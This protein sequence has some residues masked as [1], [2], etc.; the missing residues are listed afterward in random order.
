[1]RR[2]FHR[3]AT[4]AAAFVTV[5]TVSSHASAATNPLRCGGLS[6]G[7]EMDKVG[8]EGTDPSEPTT[9]QFTVVATGCSTTGAVLTYNTKNGSATSPDDFVTQS[10]TLTWAAGDSSNPTITVIITRDAVEEAPE[11]DFFVQL[12]SRQGSDTVIVDGEAVGR[13][14]D[15]DGDNEPEMSI[16]SGPYCWIPDS[17]LIPVEL[18]AV[19][20]ERVTGRYRLIPG[21]ARE[22]QDYE[23]VGDGTVVVEAG[24]RTGQAVVRLLPDRVPEA[25]ETFDIELT[26]VSAGRI[27]VGRA[28][29]TIRSYR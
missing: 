8:P 4:A 15:D 29:V 27:G 25:D 5:V 21:T 28:T 24:S 9:A 2:R 23:L 13:I 19:A 17:C 1:M 3:F 18:S 11:E 12:H 26:S 20:T 16:M 7:F 10:G 14:T 6:V 22:G